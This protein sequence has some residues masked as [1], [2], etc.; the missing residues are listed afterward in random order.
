MPGSQ[1]LIGGGDVPGLTL[2]AWGHV[3]PSNTLVKGLGV[4]SASRVS[5]GI[6]DIVLSAPASQ[7]SVIVVK[8]SGVSVMFFG[9]GYLGTTTTGRINIFNS[10]GAPVDPA[11]FHFAIYE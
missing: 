4:A 8:A 6:W 9:A 10:A 7:G 3:G 11:S 1:S 2:K 5:T